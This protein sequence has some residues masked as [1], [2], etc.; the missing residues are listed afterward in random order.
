MAVDASK[1]V[2]LLQPVPQNGTR[3]INFFNGRLLSGEDL[4]AEQKANR[5]GHSLLGRA[6]GDGVVHGLEVKVAATVSTV[7]SPVLS[8]T[9]GLALNKNG[10]ALS[11]EADTNVALSRPPDVGS[12]TSPSPIFQDCQPTQPG[13]YIA[14]AG[15]YLLTIGPAAT[16]EGL[17]EVSGVSTA[18]ARCNTKYNV[19]DVQ[20]RLL[21]LD[22]T[23]DELNDTNHLRNLVAYR[24]FGVADLAAFVVDP[25]HK[26]LSQYGLLDQ[27]RSE[28]ILTNCEVPLAVLY[29]TASSGVVFVDVWAVR[30]VVTPK[31]QRSW[32][33]FVDKRALSEATAIVLQFEDQLTALA[34]GGSPQSIV[35]SDYFRYLPPVGIL[36]VIDG[37][38]ASGFDHGIFFSTSQYRDPLFV[39]GARLDAIIRQSMLYRPIDLNSQELIWLYRVRENR[40]PPST[41]GANTAQPYMVFVT[42]HAPRYGDAHYQVARWD[43]SNYS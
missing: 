7:T 12:S 22:F 2:D 10:A 37:T 6:I 16:S 40:Q 14:G 39:N 18:Q 21:K 26:D 29:W 35:A 15:V 30:R 11:L 31:D 33:F 24:C 8:V 4:S 25:F 1:L 23:D 20:F 13:T 36:P 5:I 41:G 43:Y 27:L 32:Q 17:A 34:A 42:G 38:T 9:R 3:S 28:K 19:Q